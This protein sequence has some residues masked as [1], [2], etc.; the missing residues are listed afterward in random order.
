[1]AAN[2]IIIRI[3]GEDKFTPVMKN[4]QAS[5][6]NLGRSISGIGQTM[7]MGITMP[8]VGMGGAAV[9]AASNFE[10]S[11]N[12]TKVVFGD[13]AGAIIAFSKTAALNLGLTQ[14]QALEATGTFGNLF[15]TMGLGL[16]EA[17]RQP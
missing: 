12:K 1:M 10:E 2:D 8:I 14:Q 11:M 5:I 3:V 17:A 6:Q 13:A 15:S 7:T 16:P 4:T 9:L